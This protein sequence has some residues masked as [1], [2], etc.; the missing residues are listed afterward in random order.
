MTGDAQPL[1]SGQRNPNFKHPNYISNEI[2]YTA[3]G[4]AQGNSTKKNKENIYETTQ[5]ASGNGFS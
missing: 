3:D 5:Q 1:I 2:F 4:Q